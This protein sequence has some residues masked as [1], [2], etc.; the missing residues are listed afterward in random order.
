MGEALT[1]FLNVPVDPTSPL[2]DSFL[3]A[4]GFRSLRGIN[5]DRSVLFDMDGNLARAPGLRPHSIGNAFV[6][7]GKYPVAHVSCLPAQ[8]RV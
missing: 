5:D 6:P 8:R 3:D 2:A 1:G 4:L 7:V